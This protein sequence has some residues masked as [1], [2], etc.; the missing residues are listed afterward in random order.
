MATLYL[1]E[2]AEKEIRWTELFK[3]L[4]P[5]P[6]DKVNSTDPES[7]A[8][9]PQRSYEQWWRKRKD[10][11]NV[12]G[13]P[14]Q[15][16]FDHRYKGKG[17]NDDPFLVEFLS[18]D[19]QNAVNFGSGLKWAITVVV[20]LATLAVTFASSAYTGGVSGIIDEFGVGHEIAI[21]GISL[22]IL[23]FAIGPL[24]WG[25]LSELYGRQVVFILT[26]AVVTAF[27]AGAAGAQD[28][29][30][31]LLMRLI[32]GIFG[33]SPMTNAGGV[34]ADMFSPK[35]R[36]LA[37]SVYASAPFLGP[38]IGPIVGGF[39]GEAVGWRWIQG[40]MGIFT[41]VLAIIGALITPETYAPVLLRRRAKMLSKRTGRV[42]RSVIEHDRGPTTVKSSFETALVRPWVLLF[43]EPIVLLTSVY[44]A[45]VFGTLFMLFAAFPIVFQLGRGW[46]NGLGGLAFTGVLIGVICGLV[47][48]ILDNKRYVQTASRT[49]GGIA[50]PEARL[51]PAFP[52]AIAIPLG[53]FWFAWTNSP[54]VHWSVCIIGT[55]PFGFGFVLISLAQLNYL[56]DSYTIYA[57]SVLAANTV[58]RSFFAAIFPLFTPRM[59]TVLGIHW[60]SSVPAF[61][62][63]A[64]LPFPFLFYRYGVSIRSR[65]RYATAAAEVMTK[66]RRHEYKGEECDENRN[67]G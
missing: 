55:I 24:L 48:A 50:P 11:K 65:C 41:G 25:P 12:S 19:A 28:V 33:S 61:G 60:A 31:L 57:A 56:I 54:S 38:A 52:A 18:N 40:V 13:Q 45:I 26:Y 6:N 27:N 8:P 2:R 29:A 49:P 7:V 67:L 59:Y 14:N 9:G 35:E 15:Q 66:I 30:T 44:M 17:T 42:Y 23:G 22:Y 1:V 36:G 51:V 5:H 34:I 47:Y 53:M 58:L 16:I 10:E 21:L 63:L 43:R 37:N 46:N 20:A 64:C 4:M 32:A 62:A 3:L 39:V